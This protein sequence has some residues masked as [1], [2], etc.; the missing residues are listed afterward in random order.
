MDKRV[1]LKLTLTVEYEANPK[2]YGTKIPEEMAKIDEKN[3]SYNPYDIEIFFG[4]TNS[5]YDFKV[6]PIYND[7]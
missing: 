6:E 5:K 1:K 4:S 7:E 2:H 3:F